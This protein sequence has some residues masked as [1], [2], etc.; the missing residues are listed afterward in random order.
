M[1]L[2]VLHT[3]KGGSGKSTLARELAVAADKAGRRVALADL[4]PQGTTTGWYQRRKAETPPL[5]TFGPSATVVPLERAG[6]EWLVI[7]TPPAVTP[8]QLLARAAVV[9]VPVRLTPDDL[10]A[11]ASIAR[12]LTSR[13]AWAFVLSQVPPRSRLV[14]GA[15]RQ[16]AALGRVAPAQIGFRADFPAAAIEGMA[17]CEF[18]GRAAQEIGELYDYMLALLETADAPAKG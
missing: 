6:L 16:L 8:A 17:A 9:L 18:G 14:P 2:L 12:S 13:P 10:L 15:M 11:A 3:P 5:V 4:D 1:H 7:D